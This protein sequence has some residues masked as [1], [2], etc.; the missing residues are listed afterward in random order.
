MSPPQ[1][2]TFPQHLATLLLTLLSTYAITSNTSVRLHTDTNLYSKEDTHT[3]TCFLLLFDFEHNSK[4]RRAP[5]AVELEA[6]ALQVWC[7]SLLS[8]DI[9]RLRFVSAC[10]LWRHFL[11]VGVL[12]AICLLVLLNNQSNVDI[13][14]PLKQQT[15]PS[16]PPSQ[17]EVSRL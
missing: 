11:R 14:A 10:C 9:T 12:F 2:V 8:V 3:H 1:H 5:S 6:A 13:S 15:T 16:C 17:T 4:T 7:S